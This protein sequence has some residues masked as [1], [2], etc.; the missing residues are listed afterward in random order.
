MC[1]F[2]R[3]I[4]QNCVTKAHH[5]RGCEGMGAKP[6]AAGQFFVFLGE[7]SY[8]NAIESQFALV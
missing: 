6:P 1:E 7:T 5:R 2:W 3:R 8:F 4:E